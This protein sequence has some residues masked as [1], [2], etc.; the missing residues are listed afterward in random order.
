MLDGNVRRV[1]CRVYDIA[2]D[3][4]Q[5]A[6]ERAL[7][8]LAATLVEAAPAGQAG[9]LNE[10]L[11]ELGALVCTPAAAA[12]PACPLREHCLACARGTVDQRPIRSRKAPTPHF[13]VV[14]GA[15]RDGQG[16]T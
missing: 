7:W 4:R 1:L 16:A 12:C 2:E 10:A 5:P 8:E 6:V 11:M 9:D 13:D 14:A 15:I 3:P